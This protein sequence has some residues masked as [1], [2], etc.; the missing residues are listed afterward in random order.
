[1]ARQMGHGRAGGPG[2]PA[3]QG[4]RLGQEPVIIPHQ[5]GAEQPAWAL[6][7]RLSAVK[8]EIP[9]RF[10]DKDAVECSINTAL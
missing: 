5:I 9:P 7:L 1:M 3:H 2:H 8:S 4:G 10:Q 6:P